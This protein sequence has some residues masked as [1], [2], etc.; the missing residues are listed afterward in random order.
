M[1]SQGHDTSRVARMLLRSIRATVSDFT[2]H[3]IRVNGYLS[4]RI[5]SRN[6]GSQPALLRH[7]FGSVSGSIT[8]QVIAELDIEQPVH[9]LHP[10]MSAYGPGHAFD[11]E[12]CG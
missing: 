10:P 2:R 12:G 8:R 4:W 5:S 11:V 3:G 1:D 7:V 9:A 6:L